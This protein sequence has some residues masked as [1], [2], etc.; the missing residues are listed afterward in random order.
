MTD[1]TIVAGLIIIAYLIGGI[2]LGVLAGRAR[3]VDIRQYGSG[4]IGASNVLRTLGS[5]AGALVW[6]ADVLKGAGPVAGARF[7]VIPSLAMTRPELWLS[8]VA[9]AAVLGHCFSPYLKL[10]GGRG[11]S[12]SLGALL[13]IHPQV[14]LAALTVWLVVITITRYISL[15]SILAAGSSPLFFALY[16]DSRYYLMLG[17]VLALILLERHRPNI[18]RL[19]AGTETKIGQKA[20]SK[21]ADDDQ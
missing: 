4:N 11:V 17:V 12:T 16:G 19:L 20:K 8:L 3:G 1:T 10:A 15:A 13:V 21:A 14:G 18:G 7:A 2:P 9:L 6:V 5:K